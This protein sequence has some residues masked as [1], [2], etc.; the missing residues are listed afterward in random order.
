MKQLISKVFIASF[1][2][3]GSWLPVQAQVPSVGLT[4]GQSLGAFLDIPSLPNLR[5]IG[6]YQNNEGLYVVRGKTYRSNAFNPMNAQELAKLGQLDLKNDYDLRTNA[7]IAA[8]PDIISSGVHYTQ[9]NVMA[10]DA[11]VA[12]PPDQLSILFQ[13]PK[14]T[15]E[16]FGGAQGVVTMFTK[17]YRGFVS[18]PSAKKNY[19]SLFL[20]LQNPTSSP[21]VFH[22]TNGKDRTG[23]AAASLYAL[24][25]I[26][27]DK[28]YEDY[29][30]S[31]QY[32]LPF[33]Q[34]EIDAFTAKGGD[35]EIPISFFGVKPA[36][37]D[38]A[39]DEMNK[40]Y[41]SIEQY[42]SKGLGIDAATQKKIRAMYLTSAVSI[43]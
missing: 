14:R 7:E 11:D 36:Y 38:A 43:K 25:G 35:P 24:L 18:M 31:N 29:L 40:R 2:L 34:K 39:F 13:D 28:I 10:D 9:F 20:S 17:S 5:D 4:P 16:K 32:L 21:N 6:G 12:I 37:L 30:L 41:G 22:C 26:S 27:K 42:F 23:W 3:A 8:V 19:R 1:I 33:H 15:A